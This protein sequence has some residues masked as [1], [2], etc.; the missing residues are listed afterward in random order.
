MTELAEYGPATVVAEVNGKPVTHGELNAAFSAVAN[1][2]NWKMP[3]NA[4]VSLNSETMAVMREAVIFFTGSVPK[5]KAIGATTNK[6]G[7]GNYKVTAKGYYL[8]IG[9]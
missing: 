8:T 5:F 7:A 2:E 1:K 3:I 9:A 4:V 6:N